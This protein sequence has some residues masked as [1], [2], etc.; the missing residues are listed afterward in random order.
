MLIIKKVKSQIILKSM[1]ANNPQG[2]KDNQNGMS[3]ISER[4]EL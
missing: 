1:G 3:H 2:K 4:G